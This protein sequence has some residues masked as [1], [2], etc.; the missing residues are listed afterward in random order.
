MG[1]VAEKMHIISSDEC[2]ACHDL[3]P[4]RRN[5]AV[6]LPSAFRTLLCSRFPLSLPL[7]CTWVVC[8]GHGLVL[9]SFEAVTRTFTVWN[10]AP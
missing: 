3:G 8:P 5:I 1:I 4:L 10:Y 7:Q 6:A 9:R 2:A